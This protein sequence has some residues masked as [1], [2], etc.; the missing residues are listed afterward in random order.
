M[1]EAADEVIANNLADV[2]ANGPRLTWGRKTAAIAIDRPHQRVLET[3][4]GALG[5][6]TMWIEY[7]SERKEW[8]E[9]PEQDSTGQFGTPEYAVPALHPDPRALQEVAAARVHLVVTYTDHTV[10]YYPTERGWRINNPQRCI[11]I[12]RGLPRTYIP[13]DQVRAFVVEECG[14][15]ES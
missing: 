13:L 8:A 5:V 6:G 4:L 2:L 11:V 10:M 7:T 3:G 12:G 15:D 1:N 9:L 14:G